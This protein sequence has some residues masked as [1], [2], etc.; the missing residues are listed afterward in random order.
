MGRT[1]SLFY[2]T[3]KFSFVDKR[4]SSESTEA[5]WLAFFE[6]T[7]VTRTV[8]KGSKAISILCTASKFT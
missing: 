3:G 7:N 6:V 1:F 4:R 5:M 2:P 8:Y